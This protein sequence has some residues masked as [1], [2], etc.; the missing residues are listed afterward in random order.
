MNRKRFIKVRVSDLEH[1][2]IK[3]KAEEAGLTV[4]DLM[5]Y[6]TLGTRLRKTSV[7][8]ECIRQLARIGSNL[9]QLARWV[10]SRK[11]RATALEVLL[12]LNRVAIAAR[13]VIKT[14]GEKDA[15]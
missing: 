5:R 4:S 7:D 3:V 14:E 1:Q 15:N 10:N 2:Q 11:D 13:E 12:W 9:N 6:R 8:K